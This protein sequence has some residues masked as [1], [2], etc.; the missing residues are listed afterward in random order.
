MTRW[1]ANWR[2]AALLRSENPYHRV[3][4]RQDPRRDPGG[5]KGRSVL[6][7]ELKIVGA[8]STATMSTISTTAAGGESALNDKTAE[9]E[10]VKSKLE[11]YSAWP[12][13]IR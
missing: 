10:T 7:R 1:H 11:E 2:I 5:L 8:I 9:L 12:T 6:S 4:I 3:E 13:P